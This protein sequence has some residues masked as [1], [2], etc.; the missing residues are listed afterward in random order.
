M[1]FPKKD[2]AVAKL[3]GNCGLDICGCSC[4]RDEGGASTQEWKDQTMGEESANG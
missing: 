4:P 2:T 3:S 1:S